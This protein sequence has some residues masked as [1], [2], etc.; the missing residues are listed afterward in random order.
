[1]GGALVR[2]QT[3]E[4]EEIRAYFVDGA[5]NGVTGISPVPTVRIQRVD[6][7]QYW[8]GSAYQAGVSNINMAQIDATNFPGLY[9]YDFTPTGETEHRIRASTTDSSVINPVQIGSIY[10][11]GYVD[12]LDAPLSSIQ[13]S[14]DQL[15]ATVGGIPIEATS[16]NTGGAIKGVSFVGVE[17]SGTLTSTQ[18]E[19][20]TYHQID[21][22]ANDIDI[23]Y[24]F[25]VTGARIGVEVSF[26]GY[27]SGGND[28]IDIQAY[29]F[30]G[31]GWDTLG[32]ITGQAGT[33][34]VAFSS[35]LLSKYTGTGSDL[36]LVYIR[37]VTPAP[38]TNP[39]LF[40]DQLIVSS[41][42]LGQS[43]GYADGAVWV[44]TTNGVAGTSSFV[45]GVADN[46]VSNWADASTI[47]T[48]V[49]LHRFRIIPGSSI[50]LTAA[51]DSF[52]L[53]GQEW[54]LDLNGQS[55]A[56]TFFEGATVSDTAPPATGSGAVFCDCIF[57][58][59]SIADHR[60]LRCGFAGTIT[61]TAAATEVWEGCYSA[62]AGTGSPSVDFGAA[63][64]NTNLNM[65]HYSGGVEIQNMNAT[66]TDTM[67]LE[68]NGQLVINAN[69]SGGTVALRGNFTITDNAGGA[70]TLS[71]DARFT[72]SETADAI[73]DE[74]RAGH[75][76]AGTYGEFTGDAA[77][78]GTD[79]A[80]TTVPLDSTTD[81]AAHAATLAA[82]VVVDGE[83]GDILTD[84]AAMQP[85]IAT[86]LDATVSSRA[87]QTSVDTIDGIV[88]DIL[89]DT[90]AMQP[91]V[92]TNLDAT[93]SSR[94]TQA[95]LDALNDLDAA[96][97]T[98]A[99]PTAVAIATAVWDRAISATQT[100]GSIGRTV[101]RILAHVAGRH[102]IVRG[103]PWQQEVYHPEDVPTLGAALEDTFDLEDLSGVDIADTGGNNPV[104]DNTVIIGGRDEP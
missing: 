100:A 8:N 90:A 85:T 37:I 81:A 69:C 52:A 72:R 2:I 38:Q 61:L 83:V 35:S 23:V 45:N 28:E 70:V 60:F 92:A 48:N 86:N 93:V 19:D 74:A 104:D 68:G 55:I 91:T 99:V 43:V 95:S 64:G 27:L 73:W 88:D 65:R 9:G 103:D 16:D 1:M 6:D 18:V 10:V 71:D 89:V 36:G 50:Q 12:N 25:D 11:G 32:T 76:T 21:D 94:A 42:V 97:V 47:A 82:V 34:N 31:A 102:R 51:T 15:A 20:G 63:V 87:T 24:G 39:T 53:I 98:A 62:V 66:G 13:V 58:S 3:G 4:T 41:I 80:N 101:L 79:G 14:V 84:T 54:T 78:R 44:D 96:A 77:M 40:V 26:K 56:G 57:N 5:H 75:A 46:P 17:A 49:G 30:V 7:D 22:T 59:I 29:D 33:T 67:S